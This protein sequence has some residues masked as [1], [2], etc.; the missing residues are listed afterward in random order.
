MKEFLILLRGGDDRMTNLTESE[1]AEHMQRWGAYM[2]NLA[3]KGHLVGG[4]PLQP[5]GRLVNN[6]GVSEEVVLSDAGEAIGGYLI[7]KANDYSQA[8]ELVKNCPIFEHNGNVEVR[9]MAP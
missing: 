9:E 4:L 7:F 6:N 3:Q 2:N 5:N 8:V 1:S